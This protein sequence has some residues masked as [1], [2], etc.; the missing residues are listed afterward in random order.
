[1][2]VPVVQIGYLYLTDQERLEE[3]M[4]KVGFNVESSAS[5]DFGFQTDDKDSS[6]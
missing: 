5:F 2:E 3:L 6:N 4:A 1:M